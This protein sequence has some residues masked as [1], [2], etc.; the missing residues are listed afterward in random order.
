MGA[1]RAGAAAWPTAA[2]CSS[3]GARSPD[4]CESDCDEADC[5]VCAA[6]AGAARSVPSTC[7]TTAG[8]VP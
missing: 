5:G 2:D 7:S 1:S 4:G 8:S 6:P 3:A